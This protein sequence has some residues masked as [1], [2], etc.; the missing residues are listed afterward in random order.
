MFIS[1]TTFISQRETYVVWLAAATGNL[2][3]VRVH[4]CAH[5]ALYMCIER[6]PWARELWGA[7]RVR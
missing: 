6:V 3:V 2:D 7:G 5:A 1:K 4:I